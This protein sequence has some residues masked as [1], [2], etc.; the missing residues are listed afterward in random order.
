[1]YQAL[2]PLCGRGLGTRLVVRLLVEDYLCDP[3]LRDRWEMTP[4]DIALQYR[5]TLVALYL[6]STQAS[7]YSV[8]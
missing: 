8:K 6:S 2:S 1:M 7:S 4:L 3:S 5:Q